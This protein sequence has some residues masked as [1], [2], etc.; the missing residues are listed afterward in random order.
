MM[1]PVPQRTVSATRGMVVAD[2]LA[3]LPILMVLLA[4]NEL[5]QLTPGGARQ[6]PTRGPAR[7]GC[8]ADPSA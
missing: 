3:C 7:R 5:S 4:P 1:F 6:H 8:I 2:A